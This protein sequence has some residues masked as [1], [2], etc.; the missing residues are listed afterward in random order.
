[1]HVLKTLG[2]WLPLVGDGGLPRAFTL[3]DGIPNTRSW[4]SPAIGPLAQVD[5]LV[6]G[7][8]FSGV[9]AA[10]QAHQ[11]GLT[12]LLLEA[13]HRIGGRTRS[14]KLVSGQVTELGGTWI[15]K[16]HQPN[17]YELTQ[18]FGLE[19]QAQDPSGDSILQLPNGTVIRSSGDDELATRYP[20]LVNALAQTGIALETGAHAFNFSQMNEPDDISFADWGRGKGLDKDPLSWASLEQLSSCSFGLS[21]EQVGMYWALDWIYSAGGTEA[22]AR[23]DP[24]GSNALKVVEGISTVAARLA[25][26]LPPGS[27]RLN[28]PVESITQN[29]AE[30]GVLVTTTTGESFLAKKVISSIPSSTYYKI[31]FTPPLPAPKRVFYAQP[32]PGYYAK[33]TLTYQRSW[34]HEA[35]WGGRFTS[36][37]GPLATGIDASIEHHTLSVYLAGETSMDWHQKSKLQRQQE[38]IEHLAELVGPTLASDARD[39]TEYNEIMWTA[40]EYIEAGPIGFFGQ[41]ALGGHGSE[42]RAPFMHVHIAGTDTAWEYK[43]YIEGAVTSGRMAASEVIGLLKGSKLA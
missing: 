8:G 42:L 11:A 18:K 2:Q 10:H 41:K 28:T 29:N 3:A 39:V 26:E 14:Y 22:M 35:G 6:V 43:G 21:S 23:E 24:D 19:L 1:M 37:K 33:A 5:V 17:I 34:W 4:S 16:V 25:D 31:K 40:E 20:A 9:S 32:R 13:K 15:N 7:G 38:V 36:M 12:V 27:V 30:Y